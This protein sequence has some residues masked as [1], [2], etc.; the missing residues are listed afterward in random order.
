VYKRQTINIENF[1]FNK[2]AKGESLNLSGLSYEKGAILIWIDPDKEPSKHVMADIPA[3]KELIEKWNG[4][5]IFLFPNEKVS[6]S[7]KPANFPK[8]P[9][10]SIFAYDKSA[11]MLSEIEHIRKGSGRNNLPVIIITD[12]SGNLIYYSE[13]YK[14]GIGEQIAKAI[15][16]LK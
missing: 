9:S 11:K 10:Q 2:Y 3:V 4:G 8:L 16:P 1:S 7:F 13:G 14:I 6:A 5:V 12:K 15:A